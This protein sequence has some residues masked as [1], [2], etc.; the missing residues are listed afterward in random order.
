MT[1][2]SP[3]NP[4]YDFDVQLTGTDTNAMSIINKVVTELRPFLRSEMLMTHEEA[5]EELDAF[6][7]EAYSGNY[8][9][10]LYTCMSWVNVS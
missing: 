8:D 6:R 1:E 10:L 4:K 7:K 3:A 2:Y 9:H 5:R